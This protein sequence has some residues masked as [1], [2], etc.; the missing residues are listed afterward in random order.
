MA[1]EKEDKEENSHESEEKEN[2]VSPELQNYRRLYAAAERTLKNGMITTE[3]KNKLLFC[4]N[5]YS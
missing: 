5:L 2:E 1:K 4:Q 3:F